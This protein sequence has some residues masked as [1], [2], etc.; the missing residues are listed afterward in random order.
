MELSS[1]DFQD[2][3]NKNDLCKGLFDSSPEAIVITAPD[4][5]VV[6]SNL[7]ARELLGYLDGASLPQNI[8]ETYCNPAERCQLLSKLSE[9]GSVAGLELD[10]R[11]KNGSTINSRINVSVVSINEQSLFITTLTDITKLRASE[12]ALRKSEEKFSNIFEASP[13]AILLLDKDSRIFDCNKKAIQVFGSS[14]EELLENTFLN[15]SPQCQPDGQN[16][17]EL[18][19]SNISLV[20]SGTQLYFPWKQQLKDG[21]LLDCEVSFRPIKIGNEILVL[22]IICDYT[23]RFRAQ[24]KIELDEIRFEALYNLSKMRDKT[25][26]EILEFVLEAAVLITESDIG[27][28]YFVNEDETELTLHAWSRNVMPQCAVVEYPVVYK[29]E[30]TGLWGEAVRLRRP[31]ITNDYANCSE[32]RGMPEGHVPV[33]RHMNIPLFDNDRIVILAGVG[34]KSSDYTQED[35]NQ[36]TLLMEG[37]W[38]ILR[39]KKADE[40]LLH[41][42]EELE[43]KVLKR[44]E[45]LTAAYENLK[46]NNEQIQREVKQRMVVEKKLQEN[47]NRFDLATRAGGIGVWERHLV[48]KKSI[49]DARMREIYNIGLDEGELSDDLWQSRVHPDDLFEAEREIQ[50]AI[51][52]SGHFDSEFRI[53]WPNGEI[54]YIKASALVSYDESGKPQSMSG[55]NIDITESKRMEEGLRRYEQII[56][57]TPDLFSLVN[58]ECKYV[59]VNDAY[60]NGF[61]RAR[62]SFI[63]SHIG[64]VIGWENFK[65][66]SEPM[67]KAAFK[68]ETV[69]YKV[70]MEIPIMGRRFMSVTYQPIDSLAGEERFVAINGH[71]LTALKIAEKDRQHIFEVSID[72]LCV[73]D[74][75]DSFIELN[76]AWSTTLGWSTEELKQHKLSGL[77]HPEDKGRT[78]EIKKRL[79]SGES[80]HHFENRYQYKDGSWKWLSWNCIADLV[81]KQVVAVVRDVTMQKKMM[82]ELKTLANTDSLTG[83]NNRRFFIEKAKLEFERFKRYGGT[84]CMIMMDIDDFKNINDTYGHDA[85][86][87]VLKE[88]VRCCRETLRTTDIFGRVGGEEFAAV[89]VHGDINTAK[90]I[91]ER[92]RRKLKKMEVEINGKV[93]RFT[94]SIGLACLSEKDNPSDNDYSLEGILKQ[95]DRCLYKAKQEGKDRVVWKL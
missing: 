11:H 42:Y 49:W 71:D 10:L 90:L 85:G 16:S 45:E 78:L 23:E 3:L 14:K 43:S 9:H 19:L 1:A 74:F 39:R 12:V 8:L 58:S 4:G 75:N 64:D 81:R 83:A 30:N 17:R 41:S 32:K 73:A 40:A 50:S 86:D 29:V 46:L 6:A 89:L 61:G 69:G 51:E 93:I 35:V 33:I 18:V 28:I 13:D 26:S 5:Y 91:A 31:T 21:T 38:Q 37:M 77:V 68:G 44:T 22:C 60:L 76:P 80:V 67:I 15:F 84:I 24:K 25:S 95:A 7:K 92:L 57:T 36:L 2:L 82:E 72:M 59:M 87:V 88:L 65:K 62:E 54:R 70:W 47:A 27:Y 20:L 55:I 53:V 66:R 48:S 63:G 34:N 56:S 52:R 79:F 94:V